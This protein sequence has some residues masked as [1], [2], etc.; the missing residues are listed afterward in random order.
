M[1]LFVGMTLKLNHWDQPNLCF[2]QFSSFNSIVYVCVWHNDDNFG[3]DA[4]AVAA[5][6]VLLFALFKWDGIL[7]DP[8]I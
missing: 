2:L 4:V 3:V 6:A 1:F 5:A 7:I 8:H